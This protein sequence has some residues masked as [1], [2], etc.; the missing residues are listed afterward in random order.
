[1][2]LHKLSPDS[3]LARLPEPQRKIARA[4][5]ALIRQAVPEIAETVL[6]GSLSYHRP[7]IG[8][9][10]KGAVCLI[11]PKPDAVHLAFIHGIAL[12]DPAHL[13]R[14]TRRSKRL[15]PLRDIAEVKTREL[16][17]L[18]EAAGKYIPGKP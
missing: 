11:T 4:L 7:K 13:L 17:G 18:I 3:F 14:G 9:R 6:W 1:M 16:A 8:G 15:I 5:R 12:P 2:P 10:V